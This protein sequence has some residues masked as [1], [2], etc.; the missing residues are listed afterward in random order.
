MNGSER[1]NGK[2]EP[3]TGRRACRRIDYHASPA[4]WA[5]IEL[6]RS[7]EHPGSVGATNR[8]ILDAII[9]EWAADRLK[10]NQPE[11]VAMTPDGGAGVFSPFRA[12][13]YD[14]GAGL[15][16]WVPT[17]LAANR[18][19][20][21]GLRVVCGARRHRD[22]Q[23]CRARSEPGKR[24]CRFHGGRSTGP[25]TAEGKARALANLRRGAGNA[26]I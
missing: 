18:A 4:A 16:S 1:S 3:N 12:R 6:R 15:P 14:F 21:S 8:A 26:A 7:R 5:A 25:K 17:W 13:A 23:P 10:N 2:S 9:C 11:S 24:R 22:G 19:K 20:Q